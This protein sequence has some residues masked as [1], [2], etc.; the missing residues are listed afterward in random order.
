M[1]NQQPNHPLEDVVEQFLDNIVYQEA[2][3]NLTDRGAFVNAFRN[4]FTQHLLPPSTLNTLAIQ[5]YSFN[6]ILE[7]SF[8]D[9]TSVKKIASMQGLSQL[10]TIQYDPT[11]VTNASCPITFESFTK[12]S[13]IT[14]MPC[15]HGFNTDALQEWL[16]ES[17]VCP[18]CRY[19]LH[20]S[21]IS[22]AQDNTQNEEINNTETGI[23]VELGDNNESVDMADNITDAVS[24]T[25]N[26]TV[27]SNEGEVTNSNEDES[28][29]TTDNQQANYTDN[30]EQEDFNST[31][32][33]QYSSLFATPSANM[34]SPFTNIIYNSFILED[35]SLMQQALYNSI[36][37]QTIQDETENIENINNSTNDALDNTYNSNYDSDDD[38]Y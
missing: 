5:P 10:Q 25:E 15:N 31:D 17:N 1:S 38:T 32:E 6:D 12:E 23:D 18:I 28:T 14:I 37:E 36:V 26:E 27:H 11:K 29:N 3:N 33:T 16:K 8:Y 13:K 19:E 20:S 7:Q 24:N 35:Q 22:Y 30:A 9:D 4:L 2:Q 34:M 21:E